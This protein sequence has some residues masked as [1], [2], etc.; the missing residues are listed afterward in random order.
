[1]GVTCIM[2]IKPIDHEYSGEI[3]INNIKR[4][5]EIK[6]GGQRDE[7]ITQKGLKTMSWERRP[8]MAATPCI[9]Q[10]TPQIP[11]KYS[12]IEV[13]PISHQ[14]DYPNNVLRKNNSYYNKW[15]CFVWIELVNKIGCFNPLLDYFKSNLLHL[16]LFRVKNQLIDSP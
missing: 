2:A 15:M 8:I 4:S 5:I 9:P 16:L 13:S 1:M 14:G 11:P 10:E 3:R 7:W 6:R 12:I